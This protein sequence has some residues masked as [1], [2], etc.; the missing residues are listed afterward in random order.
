VI[1]Q[2][3]RVF[4]LLIQIRY[5]GANPGFWRWK[6]VAFEIDP[7]WGLFLLREPFLS[8]PVDVSP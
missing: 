8:I 6:V 7:F 5:T 3:A 2:I 4:D 1:V